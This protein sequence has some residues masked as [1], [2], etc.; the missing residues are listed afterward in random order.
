M[1][2]D[3]GG[4]ISRHVLVNFGI[5]TALWRLSFRYSMHYYGF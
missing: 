2:P 1:A 4:I 5:K 3:N